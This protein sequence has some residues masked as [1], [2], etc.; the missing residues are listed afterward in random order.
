MYFTTSCVQL[1]TFC[2]EFATTTTLASLVLLR[3][4]PVFLILSPAECNNRLLHLAPESR[5][6][7]VRRRLEGSNFGV[8]VKSEYKVQVKILIDRKTEIPGSHYAAYK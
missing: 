4:S 1:N 5:W 6:L 2:F 7:Q 3:L 8:E